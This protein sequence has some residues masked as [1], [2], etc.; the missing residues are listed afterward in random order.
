MELFDAIIAKY[1]ELLE[2]N[3]FTDNVIKL[4]DDSDGLGAYILKWEYSKPIPDGL[5]L[6]K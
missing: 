1:P 4:Q 6:G 5:K 2:S 3:A